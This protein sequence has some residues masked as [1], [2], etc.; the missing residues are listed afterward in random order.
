[1]GEVKKIIHPTNSFKDR[2]LIKALFWAGLRREKAAGLDIRD[3]D[4]ER[5]IIKVRGKG[6]KT[7]ILLNA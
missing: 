4:F 6:D 7:R 1:M 5:K 2:Y 3:I